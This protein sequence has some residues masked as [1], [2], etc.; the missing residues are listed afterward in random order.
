MYTSEKMDS[1]STSDNSDEDE[2]INYIKRSFPIYS[3]I[4]PLQYKSEKPI[5]I[6]N[7][8]TEEDFIKYNEISID[9]DYLKL[10]S[11]INPLTGK[12]IK[13]G[14]DTYN[15]VLKNYTIKNCKPSDINISDYL[16]ETAKMI[17]DNILYNEIHADKLKKYNDLVDIVNAK[18]AKYNE[19]CLVVIEKIK[20]LEIWDSFVEFNGLKY[21]IPAIYENIHREN[22]CMGTISKDNEL[23]TCFE[24]THM[25]ICINPIKLVTKCSKCDNL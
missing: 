8:L 21:G 3:N 17:A 16:N 1:H 4:R 14:G 5:I 19:E 7:R 25:G 13:I 2:N 15:R 12:K 20:K 11:G 22:D 18:Y 24:C 9:P 23:C 6:E 10:L